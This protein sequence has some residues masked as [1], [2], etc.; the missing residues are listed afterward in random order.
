LT[1]KKNGVKGAPRK[2]AAG[3]DKAE[4]EKKSSPLP[5]EPAQTEEGGKEIPSRKKAPEVRQ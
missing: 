2:K 5:G 4:R 1:T 3:N